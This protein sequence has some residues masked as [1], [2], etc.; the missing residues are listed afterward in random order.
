MGPSVQFH[1]GAVWVRGRR[2]M[3]IPHDNWITV[4]LQATLGR[5]NSTWTLRVTRPGG[6]VQTF[7]DLPCDPDWQAARWVGFISLSPGHAAFYLDDLSMK[8]RN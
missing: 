8:N 4:T 2:L 1:D 5:P 7:P 6:A 3:T